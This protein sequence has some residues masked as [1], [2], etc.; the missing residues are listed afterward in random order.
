MRF[1]DIIA[2]MRPAQSADEMAAIIDMIL[3]ADDITEGD[4]TIF[5]IGHS[6]GMCYA[7]AALL[8]DNDPQKAVRRLQFIDAE[9]DHL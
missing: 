3:E 5:L 1:D 9:I 6:I 7:L 2:G 8:N 4:R